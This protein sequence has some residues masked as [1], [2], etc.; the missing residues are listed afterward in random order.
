MRTAIY[1]HATLADRLA[2]HRALASVMDEPP[3]RQLAHEAAATIGPDDG[4]GRPA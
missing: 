4:A 3:T 1:T 2:T